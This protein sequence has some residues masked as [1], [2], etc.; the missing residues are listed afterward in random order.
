MIHVVDATNIH[1]Y[2]SEMEQVYRL[3]HDIFVRDKGWDD[4]AKPDQREIDQFDDEHAVHLLA[5]QEGAL[6]G[7]SRLL[8][9]TRPYLLSSVLPELCDGPAPSA[10]H[11]WEWGRICVSDRARISG[12]RLNPIALALTTAIVEWGLP[13]GV[14]RFISQNPTS[15]LLRLIQLHFR[16]FPL[17]LP[18]QIEGEE[19]IAVEAGFDE[20]TL[21]QL[22]SVRGEDRPVL[23]A[24][25]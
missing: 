18:R 4:L 14:S 1:R 9:T 13:R 11:I 19:I 16:A 5:M 10:P 8:P 17:G 3:R 24:A 25:A 21:R 2:A 23:A 15:W 22:R 6:L 12:R 7:Y 20:R